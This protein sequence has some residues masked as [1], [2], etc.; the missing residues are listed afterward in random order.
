M[1]KWQTSRSVSCRWLINAVPAPAGR[2]IEVGHPDAV[3]LHSLAV[4][5]DGDL[6]WES[7]VLLC[8]LHGLG[9]EFWIQAPLAG[10]RI[11]GVVFCIHRVG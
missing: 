1:Q 3:H 8:G 2:Q 7:F 6:R 4:G 11:G 5:M 10:A 9:C